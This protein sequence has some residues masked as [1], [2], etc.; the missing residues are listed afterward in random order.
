M[1][2]TITAFTPSHLLATQKEH[3]QQLELKSTNPL[4]AVFIWVRQRSPHAPSVAWRTR[5]LYTSI[6]RGKTANFRSTHPKG[7]ESKGGSSPETIG[8]LDG[9]WEA[10]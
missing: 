2:E 4:Q 8:L 1:H 7:R 9:H 10:G 5:M 6:F 3:P